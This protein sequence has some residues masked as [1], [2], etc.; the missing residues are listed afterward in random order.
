[1][2]LL[3]QS[4]DYALFGDGRVSV[5]IGIKDLS[6][7][8]PRPYPDVD[9]TKWDAPDASL[10]TTEAFTAA[11]VALGS[12][13][14]VDGTLITDSNA[15]E[16]TFIVPKR[17]QTAASRGIQ[18]YNLQTSHTDQDKIALSVATKLVSGSVSRALLQH[19]A[20]VQPDTDTRDKLW[21]SAE[22]KTWAEAALA[23]T[24]DA[25]TT[26]TAPNAVDPSRPHTFVPTDWLGDVCDVCDQADHSM[27]H[28]T[29][30]VNEEAFSSRASLHAA[31]TDDGSVLS[32]FSNDGH[33]WEQWVS[34]K[35]AWVPLADQTMVASLQP[36]LRPIDNDTAF[37]A[38]QYHVAHTTAAAPLSILDADAPPVPDSLDIHTDPSV[39]HYL[40]TEANPDVLYAA[41]E[42]TLWQWSP[43][44]NEW[45]HAEKAL[46]SLYPVSEQEAYVAAHE[47][48]Y[49]VPTHTFD[50]SF[51][52]HFSSNAEEYTPEERS[53][54]ASAQ[55]RD[56][57][58]RFTR[59]G[60]T[61]Q[62][63][64]NH[65]TAK[66][67]GY[68]AQTGKIT[69]EYEDG[70]TQEIDAKSVQRLHGADK[71]TAAPAA[72]TKDST[73]APAP[74]NV[75]EEEQA[76][77]KKATLPKEQPV[78]TPEEVRKVLAEYKAYI[79]AERKRKLQSFAVMN[80]QTSDV[81]PLYIAEVDDLDPSAV[82]ELIA[83]V[84]KSGASTDVNAYVRQQ[85]RWVLSPKMLK[86][87]RATVPPPLIVLDE[88]TYEDV[89][90]QVD[91]WYGGKKTS[92][93][94]ENKQ[95]PVTAAGV[96][97]IADTPSDVAAA[98]R[99]RRYWLHGAGAAKIRW[100][101]P[102]DWVRCH[103]HLSKY[104]GPRSKGYCFSGD[105][106][107]LTQKGVKTFADTV[108]T[109]QKV[110]T[111]SQPAQNALE[112]PSDARGVWKE[113]EI[114]SF[115]EQPLLTITLVRG[116]GSSTK[117]IRA[118]PEHLWFAADFRTTGEVMTVSTADLLPGMR[119][120]SLHHKSDST[121][122]RGRWVVR[123]VEDH[124]DVEEVFC[125]VVPDTEA[126]ALTDN[127]FTHNCQNLHKAATGV[128]TGSKLNP[129]RK[130]KMLATTTQIFASPS[131]LS[132]NNITSFDAYVTV[133]EA[134]AL[135]VAI[136]ES[137]PVGHKLIVGEQFL[138]NTKE[139]MLTVD[140]LN[141]LDVMGWDIESALL[142]SD[143][144]SN[145]K[146]L[147]EG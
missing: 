18:A 73:R 34:E 24:A 142:V 40:A 5:I 75:S 67:K 16:Q 32:V 66:V 43:H 58:G 3:G 114:Q 27:V 59:T 35:N 116:G 101:T 112:Q 69:V 53:K 92:A 2:E 103:R 99:L 28:I 74:S 56:A 64:R 106:E 49:D 108:G 105:T 95:A 94:D 20:S 39:V 36:E 87:I 52:R 70:S 72:P 107:F 134:T 44:T 96:P 4:Q 71:D 15:A 83:L 141:P 123:S 23:T 146:L 137:R 26:T 138:V 135:D 68:N 117:V 12:H 128:Y 25:P 1:M 97:G 62:E 84:P 42:D 31:I 109:T 90:Q 21:G 80:P 89:L 63:V 121:H 118:T 85:K 119:L 9:L 131:D 132:T 65:K 47:L 91:A 46:S 126:F 61:V 38:V 54:N 78:L 82:V 145:A 6:T 122:V 48:S 93:T 130:H 111:A 76:S 102:G 13:T 144:N 79:A 98:R 147:V 86:R 37:L 41:E 8:D 133:T 120:S 100:G 45:E 50:E 17:V 33:V 125:A 10:V 81:N 88:T 7:F 22:A 14:S 57:F 29:D 77:L 143:E 55:A 60:D 129:G 124:G 104:L 139:G 113:A 19:L 51:F 110:L 136:L 127:I 30:A 11:R 115:G 140:V